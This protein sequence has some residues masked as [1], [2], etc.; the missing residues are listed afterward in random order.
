MNKQLPFISLVL[1]INFLGC[2]TAPSSAELSY[3]SE[4]LKIEQ[5]SEHTYMHTSFLKVYKNYPCNG[6]IYHNNGEAI[7][8]DTPTDDQASRELLD[9]I[10]RELQAEVKAVVI[11]HFH[12]D[13]L[14]GLNEFHKDSITSYANDRTIQL[15]SS[16]RA[17]NDAVPNIGFKESQKLTIGKEVIENRYFGEAHAPDNIVSYIPSEKVLFGGCAI[18]PLQANKG[19]LTDANVEE[20][21]NTVSDIKR[22]YAGRIQ[23][24]VPGHGKFGGADLLDYTV[25][26]FKE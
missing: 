6:L 22:E 1:L 3:Q 11:N 20:W 13:C 18:K 16:E 4:T 26:L 19:S 5:V 7:V 15:S 8:F 2:K 14:G 21:S 12:I 9:W 25:E 23:Y 17:H 24:V 10:K